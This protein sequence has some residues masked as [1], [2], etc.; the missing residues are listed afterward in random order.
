MMRPILYL[1]QRFRPNIEAT[2]KEVKLLARYFKGNIHDL[3]LDG[4]G[5]YEFNQN[6]WSYHFLYY[7]LGII[8]LYFKTRNKIIH[9]YTSLCDRPYLPFWN[10]N[11]M[12]LTSTN[13]F[14]RERIIK[15]IKNIN[16][17]KKIIVQ[18]E[19]QRQELLQAGISSPK[20]KLIYPPVE[21]EQFTYQKP[22]GKFTILDASCPGKVRDLKKRGI[23]LLLQVDPYLT[24][25]TIKFLW[26]GGE[27]NIFMDQIKNQAFQHI[28]IENKIYTNM[29]EQYAAVHCTI[30]P[31]LQ[32]DEYLKL[33]PTSA[34]ESL[35]AGKPVLVSSETGIAEII[36]S[37]SCGVVF[38][39]RRESLLPAL[40]ELKK[41]Y[42]R[43]QRNCRRTAEKYFSGE[44]FL[45]KHEQ[46]YAEIEQL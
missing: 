17:V 19:L 44:Q 12:I 40:A 28:N 4:Y 13:F 36:R 10:K 7:P 22:V 2:S 33:I 37:N 21:L 41:N 1:T 43:Y 23:S 3:H 18:S 45:Q 11:N 6:L 20:I 46:L 34:I 32:L 42:W 27:F 8:P 9:L 15:N 39:P 29:N 5:K 35:A 25:E 26:R 31:Y 30:I 16:K 14:G 24:D 38:E